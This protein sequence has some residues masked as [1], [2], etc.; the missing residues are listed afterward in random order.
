MP[1]IQDNAIVLRRL[2]YSESSQ[3]LAVFT[4]QHGKVRI[5]AKGSRKATRT[6]FSPGIDLLECGH[7]SLFVRHAGQE[8]LAT[9]SEWKP[10]RSHLGLRETLPRIESAQ[11]I[12]DV[13]SRLTEDWEPHTELFDAL[14]GA[15]VRLAAGESVLRIVAEYQ[16]S[17][18]E[19]AGLWPRFDACASCGRSPDTSCDV[20]FSSLEGGVLCRDCE[21]GRTEKRLLRSPLNVFASWALT[22]GCHS[23]AAFDVLDYHI[24]YAMGREPVARTHL[25]AQAHRYIFHT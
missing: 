5:I 10:S 4:R 17:I 18:L 21:A 14:D 25:A 8:A 22:E 1:H 24:A 23:A 16:K 3:I 15:L 6:R 19:S 11:Y 9:L 7:I 13:T 2:D 12:A 20:Y